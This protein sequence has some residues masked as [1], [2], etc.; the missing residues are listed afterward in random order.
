MGGGGA[1]GGVDGWW[2]ARRGWGAWLDGWEWWGAPGGLDAALGDELREHA[3][4]VRVVVF[5]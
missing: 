4:E 3:V 5:F 2:R 1:W